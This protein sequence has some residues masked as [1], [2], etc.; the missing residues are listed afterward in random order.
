MASPPSTRR[1]RR[2]GRDRQKV[3]TLTTG[4]FIRRFL[5]HVLPHGFHR[6]H[7]DGLLASGTRADNIARARRLL[8][9]PPAQPEAGIPTAPR[10]TNPG[11]SRTPVRACG[12]RMSVI[13]TFQ[14]GRSP[15]YRPA[16]SPR[17]DQGRRIMINFS[18]WQN[19]KT[20]LLLRRIST[21]SDQARPAPP[22]RAYYRSIS[23]GDAGLANCNRPTSFVT[24]SIASQTSVQCTSATDRQR[25]NPHS[26]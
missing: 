15:R 7:H 19:S 17:N 13:E 26:V 4:E 8:D 18:A 16:E 5:I 1:S 11:R 14:R 21:G 22:W 12:G 2:C 10:L 6:I 20:A 24:P 9:V 25:R 3:M 23:A